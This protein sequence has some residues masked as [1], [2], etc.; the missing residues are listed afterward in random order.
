MV[1]MAFG[2]RHLHSG[3]FEK[4]PRTFSGGLNKG[5]RD[6][7]ALP[8]DEIRGRSSASVGNDNVDLSRDD[9]AVAST[10]DYVVL[11]EDN[12][13][14]LGRNAAAA[15]VNVTRSTFHRRDIIARS[16]GRRVAECLAMKSRYW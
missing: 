2:M 6:G 12:N 4:D 1:Y 15:Y 11:Y 7:V 8:G 9:R 14:Y 10:H 13:D 5:N 3:L 16:N